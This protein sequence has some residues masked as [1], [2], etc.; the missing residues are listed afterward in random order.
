MPFTPSFS[1]TLGPLELEV[2]RI[3]WAHDGPITIRAIERAINDTRSS[4]ACLAYTT[5]MTTVHRLAEPDKG[6]LQSAGER[7]HGRPT[8][9]VAQIDRATFLAQLIR[10]IARELGAT[11]AERD[12]AYA[13]LT[14]MRKSYQLVR[15]YTYSWYWVAY[16]H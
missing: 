3:V 5:I 2:M 16:S 7:V 14:R 9:Y 13:S 6:M 4:N 8:S 1:H 12:Y 15:N 10:Q 11:L